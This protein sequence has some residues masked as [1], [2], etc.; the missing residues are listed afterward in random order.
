MD[1]ELSIEI[2]EDHEKTKF[3]LSGGSW[4]KSLPS[5]NRNF[6]VHKNQFK[7]I[8][9]Q[10]SDSS[11]AIA[12]SNDYLFLSIP[13]LSSLCIKDLSGILENLGK[14]IYLLEEFNFSICFSFLLL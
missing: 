4:P 1:K 6:R 13:D 7:E 12:E 14:P 8:H 2:I 11:I 5:A 10:Y 3:M 9:L